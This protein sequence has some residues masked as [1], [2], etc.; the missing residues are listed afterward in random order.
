MKRI[1]ALATSMALLAALPA[2]ARADILWDLVHDAGSGGAYG[3]SKTI[4]KTDLVCGPLSTL[5]CGS[6][7]ASSQSANFV[8]GNDYDFSGNNGGSG[9]LGAY[10]MAADSEK[11]LGLCVPGSDV[12]PNG[13]LAAN[14]PRKEIDGPA[15]LTP[16][17]LDLTGVLNSGPVNHIWL[18]SVQNNSGGATLEGWEIYGSLVGTGPTTGT[19]YT[20]ICSGAGQ[21]IATDIA[22]CAI[23]TTGYKFLRIAS[24]NF[25]DLSV[26]AIR[27]NSI[28][29]EPGT[30]GLLATG[31]VALTGAGFIRRRKKN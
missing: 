24:V 6:V 29:P 22:D 16:L 23:P 20:L 1:S 3:V 19:V 17:Y 26:Q 27:F 10:N 7:V 14:P 12:Q 11:G 18:S 30:M 8:Y 15:G 2:T 31:L 9:P 5:T 4:T 25:G 13:C 28:V 21:T